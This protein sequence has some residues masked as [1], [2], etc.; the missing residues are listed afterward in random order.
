MVYAT[1]LSLIRVTASFLKQSKKWFISLKNKK[2]D[3]YKHR[4]IIADWFILGYFFHRICLHLWQTIWAWITKIIKT[5]KHSNLHATQKRIYMD[6][7][8]YI[9]SS[10]PTFCLSVYKHFGM[11]I[12]SAAICCEDLTLQ[13]NKYIQ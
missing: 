6:I 3:C 4:L 5:V 12:F 13:C 7:Y 8:I 2:N 11:A 9:S 1:S 10:R